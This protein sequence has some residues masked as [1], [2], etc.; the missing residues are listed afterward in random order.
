MTAQRADTL[1]NNHPR[2]DFGELLLYGLMRSSPIESHRW[3]GVHGETF[4]YP[5]LPRKHADAVS[6]ANYRGYVAS[7][8]LNPD[9]SLTLVGYQYEHMKGATVNGKASLSIEIEEDLVNELVTGDFWMILLPDFYSKPAT[10]VP[11]CDGHI[12]EDRSQWIVD[13]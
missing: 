4:D 8:R 11:F 6:T 13:P 7:L 2:V 3:L 1:L 5:R 9:G 12:V 10:F